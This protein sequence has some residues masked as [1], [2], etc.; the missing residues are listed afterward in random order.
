VP[1]LGFSADAKGFMGMD[2]TEVLVKTPEK[3][4]VRP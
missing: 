4:G 3:Q 2:K 1:L